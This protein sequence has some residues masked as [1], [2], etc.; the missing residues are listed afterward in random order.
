VTT[1]KSSTGNNNSGGLVGQF[2][3]SG[4]RYLAESSATG[5][6]NATQ[7]SAGAV[8]SGGLCG[9]TG[10]SGNIYVLNCFAEGNVSVTA[11]S[12][13]SYF[14][15]LIGKTGGTTVSNSWSE[16]TVS[17]TAGS[18][19]TNEYAG[20]LIGMA[21]PS[22]TPSIPPHQIISHP[23]GNSSNEICRAFC[24]IHSFF[25]YQPLLFWRLLFFRNHLRIRQ[26]NY[27][28]CRR[29]YRR[30]R[31]SNRGDAIALQCLRRIDVRLRQ[32]FRGKI[33]SIVGLTEAQLANT[34]LLDGTYVDY[35]GTAPNFNSSGKYLV[36]ALNEDYGYSSGGIQTGMGKR[37]ERYPV[38]G[39]AWTDPGNFEYISKDDLTITVRKS[40]RLCCCGLQRLRFFRLQ[41][42]RSASALYQFDR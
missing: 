16:G 22:G 3:G 15:G 7:N 19:S 38:F 27:L 26:R 6:V 40:L 33:Y 17:S 29:I 4:T 21:S 25:S 28:V 12:G 23:C 5:N 13:D 41:P 20:G 10:A 35:A 14:G 2:E 36:D 18:A 32:L 11:A 8:Y 1:A 30:K 42:S 39:D 34:A 31:R 37:F 24:R 9:Q